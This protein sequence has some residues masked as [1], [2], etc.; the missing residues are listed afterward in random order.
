MTNTTAPDELVLETP[1]LRLAALA[2]GPADGQPV[3]AL[4]GWLDNAASFIRL[5]PLLPGC[6]LVA[7][8]LT[9]H[10]RSDWRPPGV[11]YHFV[12]YVPDVLAALNALG[13]DR[14][15]LLGHS[16]GAGIA[17]FL[18]AIAPER[19]ERLALIEGLGPLSGDPLDDVGRLAAATAQ[20]QRNTPKRPPVYPTLSAA[21]EARQRAG[22][23]TLAA[24][25]ALAERGLKRTPQGYT[26]RSDPRLTFKSPVYLTE[27]QVLAFLAR[28]TPPTLLIRGAAGYL[29]GRDWMAQRYAVLPALEL[30]DLPG[31]HHLHLD[32]P[33]TSAQALAGFLG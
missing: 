33:T 29:H 20:M 31:G 28:V 11:A 32:D 19:I 17:C 24:A 25:T 21:A 6:R 15:T 4:H 12:D 3:L 9:G 10:G 5:A 30:V 27:A 26:W 18:T 22:D 23:L 14:C 1:Y 13:W 7:L 2:F 8:D 16:L